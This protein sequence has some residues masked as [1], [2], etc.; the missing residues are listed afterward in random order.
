[1][2]FNDCEINPANNKPQVLV[3]E[4]W[5]IRTLKSCNCGCAEKLSI[6]SRSQAVS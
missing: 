1:M 5:S 4:N 6:Y 3:T 2:F